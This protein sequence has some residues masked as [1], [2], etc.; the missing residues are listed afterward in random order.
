MTLLHFA[1]G[2]LGDVGGCK[3]PMAIRIRTK[4]DG[5]D[6]LNESTC[7]PNQARSSSLGTRSED[8]SRR[9]LNLPHSQPSKG[10]VRRLCSHCAPDLVI[11]SFIVH[12]SGGQNDSG[13][14]LDEI[15]LRTMAGD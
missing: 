14:D 15:V 11:T 3:R 10:P 7:H 13:L 8:L 4:L 1:I 5:S 6:A 2:Q 12:D 9:C